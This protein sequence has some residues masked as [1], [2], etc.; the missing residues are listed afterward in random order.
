MSVDD[1]TAD[2]AADQAPPLFAAVA[3]LRELH[4]AAEESK[5]PGIALPLGLAVADLVEQLPAGDARVVD[6]SREGLARLAE[7]PDQA[8]TPLVASA[9]LA[10]G[11]RLP[12]PSG[13]GAWRGLT[14]TAF[15][16]FMAGADVGEWRVNAAD[17]RRRLA[18]LPE[19]HPAAIGLRVVAT[20]ADV[21]DAMA[22]GRWGEAEELSL[23]RLRSDVASGAVHA[24]PRVGAAAVAMV[25]MLQ[26]VRMNVR[27]QSLDPADQPSPEEIDAVIADLESA[28][29]AASGIP[30]LPGSGDAFGALSV[31]AAI[32]LISWAGDEP[33]AAD[34][35]GPAPTDRELFRRA[36]E[37][38][39]DVPPAMA[40]LADL[41]RA[42]ADVGEHHT[43]AD[44][45]SL[46]IVS[47]G[48]G[49]FGAGGA[50]GGRLARAQQLA[51]QARRTRTP[52]DLSAAI[53]EL[54]SVRRELA[55]GHP[56]HDH[57]LAILTN[58][59]GVRASL[60]QSPADC[61]EAINVG[62]EA[63][64]ATGAPTM[65]VVGHLV[66]VLSLA[67]LLDLRDGPYD[68]AE[69]ALVEARKAEP[70]AVP[71]EWLP[72]TLA[73]GIGIARMLQW[74]SS[75]DPRTRAAGRAALDEA[76]RLMPD[77]EATE[78]W[79]GRAWVL[80]NS[81]AALATLFADPDGAAAAGR[82]A[83]RLDDVLAAHPELADRV[84][85][86]TLPGGLSAMNLASGGAGLRQAL[87]LARDVL[88]LLSGAG[89]FGFA[90]NAFANRDM[91]WAQVHG[92]LETIRQ[93][94]GFGPFGAD[95][96]AVAAAVA[97]LRGGG[98]D[99]NAL[100]AAAA[101]LG[102]DARA[103]RHANTAAAGTPIP[104]PPP[105][106]ATNRERV[107]AAIE[108]AGG[109][110][111]GLDADRAPLSAAGGPDPDVLQSV[112]AALRAGLAGGIDDHDLV[113]RTTGTLGLVMAE[114]HWA[115]RSD[116]AAAGD[117]DREWTAR[118]AGDARAVTLL[119]AVRNL[120]SS[121]SSHGHQHP[122]PER[123]TLLDVQARCFHELAGLELVA[124][125]ADEAERA[126]R[127]AL[128]ELGR[129]VAVT[130]RNGDAMR[131]AARA[132]AVLGRTVEWCLAAGRWKAAVT[133][134]E[135]GR[136][137]VLASVVL[138]GRV[139]SL[140]AATG[141][142]D[143]LPGWQAG[144]AEG[145]AAGLAAVSA[146]F[147]GQFAL[148]PPDVDRVSQAMWSSASTLD[149]VVYL[150]PAP[151]ADPRDRRCAAGARAL[152]VRPGFTVEVLSL[153][154]ARTGPGSAVA[155]YLAALD[156]ALD[157]VD[158]SVPGG[159][160]AGPGGPEWS[161]ALER[162]G[163][164]AHSAVVGPLV[165]HTRGW[166]LGRLPHL[167]LI[168]LGE[169]AAVPYAAAWCADPGV[170]GGRRYTAHDLVLSYLASAR[171]VSSLVVRR[172]LPRDRR[173]VV[174]SDAVGDFPFS[175][176]TAGGIVA[177]YGRNGAAPDEGFPA[178]HG[179]SGPGA[180]TADRLLAA[181]LGSDDVAGASVL[182]VTT[183]GHSRPPHLAAADRPLP[184]A[185]ILDA[186]RRRPPDAPGGLVVTSACLTD[187]THESFDESLTLATG[188][189]AAGATG[190]VGTRWPVDDDTAAVFAIQ[191]HHRLGAGLPPAHALR[192]AQLAMLDPDASLPHGLGGVV[193]E[194]LSGIPH[195]RLAEP[196]SWAGYVH[197][198]C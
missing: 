3:R 155:A 127:A 170:P 147:E 136:G 143:L 116:P 67:L 45:R 182:H 16:D 134:A 89:P 168:P 162:L 73:T 189:L 190:V 77:V 124:G 52:A 30:P 102:G 193:A 68:A 104:E 32:C 10:L 72:S 82:L 167:A 156:G 95:P 75:D 163:A 115:G 138:A 166:D 145:R 69:A 98:L 86:N 171:I 42:L 34:P 58:L 128:T 118:A 153:P 39:R 109:V 79:V 70:A 8:A 40:D 185:E 90:A 137:L 18:E 6:L 65:E 107:T 7:V 59:L 66:G 19:G 36:R 194:H 131:V 106:A 43:A 100:A 179:R 46:R 105:P 97:A 80:F 144:T 103:F 173:V 21:M 123:A 139:S 78:M 117:L 50:M 88:P 196:A 96:S 54:R 158:G 28:L 181:I 41:L 169:L 135:E 71:G 31:M 132:N 62:I 48:L 122:A 177:Q 121:L 101:A 56:A 84:A 91:N 142:Q 184:V 148:L 53:D 188:L 152:I 130:D 25:A 150:V 76:E 94:K 1:P 57:V 108:R 17:A 35:E 26:A 9:R 164:W 141:R 161:A 157:G 154:A 151:P 112:A 176:N 15:S 61:A 55:A 110:G 125:A 186:S 20:A 38:L 60:T 178:V 119:S 29:A 165:S 74:R 92:V 114:L 47:E 180:A 12:P 129:C 198:G 85:G 49:H 191:L 99:P 27:R 4:A 63:V 160:R 93:G 14:G 120:D 37:H 174:V 149:A 175:R 140:L 133:V 64:R 5:R 33:G 197:H 126:A 13:T 22:A 195:E 83:G 187:T 2:A 24:D 159:F 146:T 81:N 87:Q 113:R 111:V 44:P 11:R 51:E 172:R 183:H 23:S 192:E